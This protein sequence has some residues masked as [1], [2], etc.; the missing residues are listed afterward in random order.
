M[1]S[2]PPCHS[3]GSLKDVTDEVRKRLEDFRVRAK[4]IGNAQ[5]PRQSA[6]PIV[7]DVVA[8]VVG[9]VAGDLVSSSGLDALVSKR[10]ASSA[11]RKFMKESAREQARSAKKAWLE[12]RSQELDRHGR[13]VKAYLGTLSVPSPSLKPEGNSVRLVRKLGRFHRLKTPDA[14]ARALVSVLDEV[15]SLDPI[16]ND[17]ILSYLAGQGAKIQEEAVQLVTNLERAIRECVT[18][19]LSATSANWWNERVPAPVRKR[20][21]NRRR[22]EK[23]AEPDVSA[24]E[25]SLSYE[26]F[27][28]YVDIIL[29]NRNWDD[30][31]Q[32]VFK[33]R[34]WISTK[35]NESRTIRNSLMHSR[36]LT[37]PGYEKLRVISRDLLGAIQRFLRFRTGGRQ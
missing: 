7:T 28:D 23:E 10:S 32:E 18:E 30:C 1:A 9:R 6:D 14:K 13:E 36:K 27:A 4:Q 31:F 21:E 16:P 37:S 26:G 11:V 24:L 20:A 2:V 33:D 22:T 34:A 3:G 25:D 12:E 8:G 19:Q 35:L 29:H 5:L 17:L 15:L